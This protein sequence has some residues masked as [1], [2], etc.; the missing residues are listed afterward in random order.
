M[1]LK[2]AHGWYMPEQDA[3]A[4]LPL[5][6][7]RIASAGLTVQHKDALIRLRDMIEDDLEL[8]RCEYRELE[9]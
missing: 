3:E 8:Q 9:P 4:L 2:Q 1:S 6:E 5:I 7:D